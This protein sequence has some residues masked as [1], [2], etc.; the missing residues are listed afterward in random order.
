MSATATA[1]VRRWGPG[2]GG[3]PV[4]LV[5]LRSTA[6]A[7]ARLTPRG[8]TLTGLDMPGATGGIGPV[9]AEVVDPVAWE[10]DTTYRGRTVGRYA[11][12]IR[13]GRFEL[14]GRT[15]ELVRQGPHQLH[16]G[17]DGF[18]RRRWSVDAVEATRHEARATFS[19]ESPAG[20]MGFPG[21][22]RVTVD[23]RLRDTVLTLA[24]RAVTDAPT[25]VN[26]TN[27][28]YFDLDGSGR[29]LEQSLGVDADHVLPVDA[30]R[31]VTGERRPVDGTAFD[32]RRL[33]RLDR[34]LAQP[35][36]PA[37]F[38]HSWLV[39]DWTPEATLREVAVLVGPRSGRRLRVATTC[40]AL[41]VFTAPALGGV[42]LETQFPA[43]A[44]NHPE[45]PSTRLDPGGV[46]RHET[47]FAFDVT[48][49]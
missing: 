29:P 22:L 38:D 48:S 4:D 7:E 44:P 28:A 31:L 43:D 16:G 23:Y 35:G 39:R 9:V 3:E 45:W 41:H 47:R 49:D 2:S 8:A 25:H 37:E 30:D 14:D 6:G 36:A 34:T 19:L 13:D 32:L 33:R 10:A 11:N 46:W 24:F 20:D 15:V 18:D 40:P 1:A 26:L 17:P 27:H 21:R 42:C 5:V 12:R